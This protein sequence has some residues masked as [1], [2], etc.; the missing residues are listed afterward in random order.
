MCWYVLV[1]V[2][3]NFLVN[4]YAMDR[5]MFKLCKN[6]NR[7][8]IESFVGDIRNETIE[9]IPHTKHGPRNQQVL[10]DDRANVT[11]IYFFIRSGVLKNFG[12]SIFGSRYFFVD[13]VRDEG[14]RQNL[15]S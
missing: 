14:V 8:I 2:D 10:R 4:S 15:K 9:H 5:F 11:F 3:I 6:F 12:D 1:I 7:Q 13:F